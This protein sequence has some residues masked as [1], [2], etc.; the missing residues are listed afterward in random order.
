MIRRA[1][2]LTALALATPGFILICWLAVREQ[3]GRP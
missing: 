2:H 1:F 3:Q